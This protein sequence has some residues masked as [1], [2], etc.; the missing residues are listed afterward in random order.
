MRA[1][2]LAARSEAKADVER[3]RR[4]MALGFRWMVGIQITT[5]LAIAAKFA[6]M[7]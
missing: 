5:L 3:L 2:L 7:Y 4:E 1:E 6:N